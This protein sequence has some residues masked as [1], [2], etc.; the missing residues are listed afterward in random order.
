[1]I[2]PIAL[3]NISVR[4]SIILLAGWMALLWL[5]RKHNPRWSVAVSRGMIAACLG[6]PVVYCALPGMP[7]VLTGLQNVIL[8]QSLSRV[9]A[10]P[11]NTDAESA[12]AR[13]IAIH[14][15]T[16]LDL[17][18]ETQ[19]PAI[20][21]P[22]VS[23]R[24]D[25]GPRVAVDDAIVRQRPDGPLPERDAT[26]SEDDRPGKFSDIATA[27]SPD[28]VLSPTQPRSQPDDGRQSLWWFVA[29]WPVVSV[30]LLMR[31]SRQYLRTRRLLRGS[32]SA[33]E[34]WVS[35]CR[36]IAERLG[37]RTAPQVRIAPG[38]QGPC[39]AGLLRPVV[40]LPAAWQQDSSVQQW[41]PV[42]AHEISHIAGCDGMWDLL[43]R[44]ATAVWW[45]H[46][47]VWRLSLRH[48]LACE[49]VC[50]AVAAEMTSGFESYRRL[51]AGWAL[52]R[53]EPVVATLAMADRSLL[54]RR[55]N[56]LER[57][58]PASR[59]VP[60]RYA[61]FVAVVVTA[62]VITGSVQF[63]AVAAA[64]PQVDEPATSA[65]PAA[66][67]PADSKQPVRRPNAVDIDT[68]RT[69]PKVVRVV[70][71]N[72]QPIAGA[73]VRVGWWEDEDGDMLGVATIDSPTTDA[74]GEVTLAVPF[75]AARRSSQPMPKAT[76]QPVLSIL[77]AEHRNSN[78]NRDA[79]CRSTQ[80]TKTAIRWRTP[81]PCCNS[82]ARSA[83]SLN[84]TSIV[85]GILRRLW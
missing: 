51:L 53:Q 65:P 74:S 47:L 39:T 76:H 6:L 63:V 9:G 33:P 61:A 79:W 38:I 37:L 55:L 70:D 19:G 4:L 36:T 73:R 21:A 66:D 24:A 7:V 46:P 30:L 48:R 69:E 15:L 84:R 16:T 5:G 81:I 85:Q 22:Q 1:M 13:P 77:S 27:P 62:I 78:W 8:G 31:I 52:R 41:R 29:A 50:D 57:C 59:L 3:L 42:L 56:W 67:S 35:E 25:S 49:Y 60:Y 10:E 26:G 58:L 28:A 45:F 80:S 72:E 64:T 2:D 54:L 17:A 71:A 20:S 44:L 83:A 11:V 12:E 32:V 43:A 75:G 14:P 23:P 40:L 82:P 34:P 18:D 68:S